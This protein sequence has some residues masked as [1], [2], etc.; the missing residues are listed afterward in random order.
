MICWDAFD[1]LTKSLAQTILR[2]ENSTGH[3]LASR[4]LRKMGLARAGTS[5]G[6]VGAAPDVESDTACSQRD[7]LR[8]AAHW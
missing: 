2:E 7:P 5:R 6:G 1:R 4:L 3:C 8:A